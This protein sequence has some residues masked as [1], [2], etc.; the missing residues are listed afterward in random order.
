MELRWQEA[1]GAH[2]GAEAGDQGGGSGEARSG[3]SLWG[4]VLGVLSRGLGRL[5]K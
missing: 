3:P 2:R 1:E 5:I 4:S